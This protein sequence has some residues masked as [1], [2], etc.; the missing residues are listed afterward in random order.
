MRGNYMYLGDGMSSLRTKNFRD[1]SII[2]RLSIRV[3]EISNLLKVAGPSDRQVKMIMNGFSEGTPGSRP[4]ARITLVNLNSAIVN[5]I[6][7]YLK[8]RGPE[9]RF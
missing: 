4:S 9:D 5:K 3:P 7:L 1:N 2:P 6:L 8:N